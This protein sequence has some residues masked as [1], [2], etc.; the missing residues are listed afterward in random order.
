M[1][2]FCPVFLL[3]DTVLNWTKTTASNGETIVPFI[4]EN[5]YETR[6]ALLQNRWQSDSSFHFKHEQAQGACGQKVSLHMIL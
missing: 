2:Y 4:W 3:L 5:R 6:D 1:Q